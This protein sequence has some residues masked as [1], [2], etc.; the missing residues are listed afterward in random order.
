[1]RN[2]SASAST[3]WAHFTADA[4]AGALVDLPGHPA[5][6]FR[7]PRVK[8]VVLLSPQGPGEFG[9]TDH[10]WDHVMLPLLSMTGSL[11]L[12]AG[13]R[14]P[15]WKKIPF[16]PAWSEVSRFYRRRESYVLY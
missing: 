1:M 15:E 6:N 12:G 13:N 11:D 2:I 4:I 5:T 14:G 7:D 16:E 8:A 10:S 3:P 9:L